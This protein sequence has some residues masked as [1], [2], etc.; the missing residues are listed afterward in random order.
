MSSRTLTHL[1]SLPI[2]AMNAAF[3]RR[4]DRLLIGGEWVPSASGKTFPSYNPATG[5]VL[6]HCAEG[7]T[8]GV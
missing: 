3:I 5:E 2:G 4:A 8:E 1:D 7:G 6:T